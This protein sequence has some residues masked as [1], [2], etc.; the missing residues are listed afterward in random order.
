MDLTE[1]KK[2]WLT[3]LVT[4]P[5][6][7]YIFFMGDE[8]LFTF[9]MMAVTMVGVWEYHQV[10]GLSTSPRDLGFLWAELFA[11]A[12]IAAA[13]F[14]SIETIFFL[15][16]I[17]LFVFA[18]RALHRHSPGLASF[19][20]L[21]ADLL[22]VLYIPCLVASLVLLRKGADG[23]RWIFLTVALA[24]FADTGAF[25][26][27]RFFGKHKLAPAISP[28]K[29]IEGAIGGILA[30]ILTALLC[31]RYLLPAIPFWG[32][33]VLGVFA[34]MSGQMGDLFESMIKRTFGKKDSGT[35]L[36][37]HG[38]ILDRV[39]ALLFASPVV[40]SCKYFFG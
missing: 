1:H 18:A 12:I 11:T 39:D 36:P 32:A 31:A 20:V 8:R 13:H 33:V 19:E 21:A 4:V 5:V 35:L 27:G 15:L 24:F 10:V 29:T 22:C 37:G 6:L 9:L 25:Y 3:A 2:R 40:Y 7:L 38:G 34:A 28:G 26:A 17:S 30:D 16:W 14:G 23:G